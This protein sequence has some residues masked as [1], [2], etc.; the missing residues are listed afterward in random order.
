MLISTKDY[1]ELTFK[2]LLNIQQGNYTP[3]NFDFSISDSAYC[4]IMSELIEY[5]YVRGFTQIPMLGRT[6][7]K[8]RNPKLTYEGLAYIEKYLINNV[9]FELVQR[10]TSQDLKNASMLKN[11]LEQRLGVKTEHIIFHLE[12]LEKKRLISI[13]SKYSTEHELEYYEVTLTS[14][15]YKEFSPAPEAHINYGVQNHYSNSTVV[16]GNVSINETFNQF[17]DSTDLTDEQKRD[18]T[19]LI[20]DLIKEKGVSSDSELK[21]KSYFSKLSGKAFE[22]V[23]TQSIIAIVKSFFG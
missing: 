22:T 1:E 9:L 7:F 23:V 13:K 20:N 19:E 3:K 15:G 10:S 17:V 8:V 5:H 2:L 4:E 11:E 6:D 12:A 18:L 14:L 16:H 21:I